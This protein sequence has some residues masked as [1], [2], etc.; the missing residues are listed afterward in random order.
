MNN[1][2]LSP[3]RPGRVAVQIHT[4][5]CARHP[6]REAAARCPSCGGFFCRECV[7]EHSGR[8]LCA[9]CL[10]KQAAGGERRRRRLLALRRQLA[11]A[12]AL[13]AAGL[14]FYALGSLLL[15]VPPDFHEGTI[16]GAKSG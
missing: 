11:L 12:A 15:N 5:R 3:D 4:Q 6:G 8:L 10:A 7:V 16:W 9:P 2:P 1:P 13:F 14:V